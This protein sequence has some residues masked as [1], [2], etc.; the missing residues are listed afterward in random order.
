MSQ[1]PPSA[2]PDPRPARG[3]DNLR[4]MAWGFAAALSIVAMVSLI[5][6]ATKSLPP[7]EV[8]FLRNLIMVAMWLPWALKGG[9]GALKTKRPVMHLLRGVSGF[10]SFALITYALS[11]LTL[12]NASVLS[13]SVPL[14]MIPISYL[15]MRE[16]ADAPRI[17]ATVCGFVGV[18]MIVRPS[19]DTDPAMFAAVGAAVV[20]C[21][22]MMA[23]KTLMRTEQVGTII[24]FYGTTS[25][26][27]SAVPAWMGWVTPTL[28][29]LG[30]LGAMSI[31]ASAGQYCLAKAY[32]A[33]DLTVVAPVNYSRLPIALIVGIVIFGEWPD[34]WSIAGMTVIL[35][36]TL[37]IS[38]REA[39]AK[40]RLSAPER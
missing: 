2:E 24:I 28:W 31:A 17:A 6:E 22:T 1:D 21:F 27:L 35:S 13:F 39:R 36:A 32:Q 33:G 37:V 4:G 19:L 30:L 18:V 40:E 3:A 20:T 14:W 9:G 15:V 34:G 11:R 5:K 38:F 8:V 23:V 26:A 12:A 25:I 7:M 16:V 10:A 29:D